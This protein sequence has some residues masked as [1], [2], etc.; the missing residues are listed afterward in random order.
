[1]DE[2]NLGK[3]P[4]KEQNILSGANVGHD[5]SIRDIRQTINYIQPSLPLALTSTPTNL[6]YSGISQLVGRENELNSLQKL[7][8][9][10]QVQ[11]VVVVGMPGVGKTALAIR[12]AQVFRENFLGGITFFSASSS[13]VGV[14][15]LDFASSFCLVPPNSPDLAE[16]VRYVWQ[17]WPL[18]PVTTVGATASGDVLLI[19]DGVVDYKSICPYLPLC[20]DRFKILLTT[21]VQQLGDFQSITLDVLT[22]AEAKTLLGAAAGIGRVEGEPQ[23]AE[24]LCEKLGY[25]PLSLKL[26][27]HYLKSKEDLT[28]CELLQRLEQRQFS[29]QSLSEDEDWVRAALDLS[30]QELDERGKRLAYLLGLFAP[31]PIRWSLVQ[32]CSLEFESCSLEWHANELEEVRDKQLRRFSLLEYRDECYQLN[33]LIRN[34]FQEKRKELANSEKLEQVYC[35]TMVKQVKNFPNTLTYKE[36]KDFAPVVPHLEEAASDQLVWQVEDTDLG[37]LF[38]G[39]GRFYEVQGAYIQAEQWRVQS[40]KVLPKRLGEEHP[41]V[42]Q[43]LNSLALL[44]RSLSHFTKAEPLFKRAMEIRKKLLVKEHQYW[45]QSLNALAYL[46]YSQGRYNESEE[47]CEQ[48][49]QIRQQ[50]LGEEHSDVAGSLNDLATLYRI[51][52]RY[53]EAEQLCKKALEMR[54]RLFGE[55]H[56]EVAQSLNN[57]SNLY[58][59]QGRYSEAEQHCK[60]A[61]EM[62]RRLLGEEHPIVAQSLNNLAEIYRNQNRDSE[63]ETLLLHALEL[64]RKLLGEEHPEVAQSL[65]SLALLYFNQGQYEKAEPLLRLALELDQKLLGKE[66]PYVA[67][68]L[69]NL[70][71]LYCSQ[72]QYV[73]AEPLFAQAISIALQSLGS[74]NPNTKRFLQNQR[75]WLQKMI[76]ENSPLVDTLLTNSSESTKEVLRSLLQPKQ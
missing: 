13:N 7:L 41:S 40:L 6:P 26:V 34:Y 11:V 75:D 76:D 17:Y 60:E 54:Q 68:C 62:R 48:A 29:T 72:G 63:A 23:Q 14:E 39:L 70:A 35:R 28:L 74:E 61:L 24:Q 55:D 38:N 52:G 25:L 49:L 46:Y 18:Q 20:N 69:N 10:D 64:N 66:H 9:H 19:F 15:I 31:Q 50:Q 30:W 32:N 58:K 2:E 16:R 53:N 45:A 37:L 51:Q 36:W 71:L 67:E 56:L 65:N 3:D 1:M 59:T 57:L 44:Y 21:Q 27:G 43:A 22:P 42:A 33:W 8:K 12:Y 47:L 4:Q 73:K 5:L